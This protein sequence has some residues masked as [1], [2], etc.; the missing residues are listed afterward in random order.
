MRALML[1]EK[2]C[3]KDTVLNILKGAN[4]GILPALTE[5]PQDDYYTQK[6]R[7]AVNSAIEAALKK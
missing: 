4:G 5:V 1:C 3:G 2:L 6:V 7:E